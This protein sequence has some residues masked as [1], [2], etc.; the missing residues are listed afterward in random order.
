MVIFFD[1]DDTLYERAK[2]FID[3]YMSIYGECTYEF[4]HNL[5]DACSY[6]GDQ[7]FLPSQRGDI[8]MEQ[9]YIYKYCN[10]FTDLGLRISAR[11]ALEF[12]NV[13]RSNQQKIVP[14]NG[15]L[16]ALVHCKDKYES[17]G[18]LTN[19]PSD[20][21]REKIANLRIESL[22]NPEL[23]VISKEVEC[24]KP[25]PRIFEIAAQKAVKAPSELIMVGDSLERDIIPAVK[26]GWHTVWL[27]LKKETP[28]GEYLPER[29]IYS[30]DEL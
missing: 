7:V 25:D 27:N 29:I 3:T 10:G 16:E 2:P 20:N 18:I 4:A 13:Y 21:Q 14:A 23:I 28:Q 8:T 1:L 24:A 15:V 26:L 5:Y 30:M 22:I 9:M 19:G 6:R 12:Q 17:V 11:E